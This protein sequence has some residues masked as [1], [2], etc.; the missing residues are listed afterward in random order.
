MSIMREDD[1]SY[2]LLQ[3]NKGVESEMDRLHTRWPGEL[4]WS[5]RRIGQPYREYNNYYKRIHRVPYEP[6]AVIIGKGPSLDTITNQDFK[7][8]DIVICCND[9]V[10]RVVSLCLKLPI[11]SV[12]LDESLRDTCRSNHATHF[13]SPWAKDWVADATVIPLDAPQRGQ[14]LLTVL[15]AIRVAKH[16]GCGFFKLMGFDAMFGK[17][18][19][20]S[21]IGYTPGQNAKRFLAHKEFILKELEGCMWWAVTPEGKN[22]TIKDGVE[23]ECK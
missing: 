12:Q 2:V 11:Y 21:C 10:H 23:T 5:P 7:R 14:K 13:I 3:T 19:Y 17:L 4:R 20:A 8:T 15:E 1:G 6:C 9:S 22:V 16:M 18:G